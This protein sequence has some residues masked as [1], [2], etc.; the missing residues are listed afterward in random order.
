[1]PSS[2]KSI[3]QKSEA[4][5]KEFLTEQ[6]QTFK[7]DILKTVDAKIEYVAKDARE[8][9]NSIA[10]GLNKRMDDMEKSLR[11]EIH[12]TQLAVKEVKADTISIREKLDAVIEK[13]DHHDEEIVFLKAAVAK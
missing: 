2:K 8:H 12:Y 1:M 5:T 9:V 13:V 7:H 6:L 3:P 10:A 11:Q 4:I